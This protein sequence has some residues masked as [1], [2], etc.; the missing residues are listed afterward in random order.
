MHPWILLSEDAEDVKILVEIGKDPTIAA[1]IKEILGFYAS[2][3]WGQYQ[4][5]LQLQIIL[6]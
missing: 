1:T 3:C 4:E 5:E 6:F 2:S